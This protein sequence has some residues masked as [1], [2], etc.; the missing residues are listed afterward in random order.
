MRCDQS[1]LDETAFHKQ[2]RGPQSLP[3]SI[4]P[5]SMDPLLLKRS[6]YICQHHLINKI[7]LC[8]FINTFGLRK[9]NLTTN[10]MDQW[11]MIFHEECITLPEANI[12][13]EQ[14][15]VGRRSFPFWD[16]FLASAMLVLGGVISFPLC[17][18]IRPSKPPEVV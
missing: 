4:C 2:D 9:D 15:M 5:R 16:G 12:S 7:T 3:K 18:P 17:F 6:I 10:T 1:L 11:E 13:P 14:R 8:H